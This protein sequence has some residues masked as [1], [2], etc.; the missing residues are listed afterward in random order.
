MLFFDSHNIGRNL[1]RKDYLMQILFAKLVDK[2]L[3]SVSV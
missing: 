3:R 2:L 1:M